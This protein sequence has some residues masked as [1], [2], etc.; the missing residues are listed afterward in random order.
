[1]VGD[2]YLDHF[3]PESGKGIDIAHGIYKKVCG[4][5]LE[6]RLSLVKAD[7]TNVNTDKN[8]REICY[9]ILNNN[10]YFA[11]GENILI[12]MLADEEEEVRV[13]AVNKLLNIKGLNEIFTCED[14]F[15]GGVVESESEDEPARR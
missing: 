14:S 8:V 15:E 13:R 3:S 11:H 7:G 5:E 1:M 6:N 10:S 4:T 12:A 2:F 9:K